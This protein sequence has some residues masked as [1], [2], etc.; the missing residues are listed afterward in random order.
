MLAKWQ[1]WL[2]LY[3]N[4]ALFENTTVH[5]SLWHAPLM[6][7]RQAEILQSHMATLLSLLYH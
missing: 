4:S 5:H 1:E 3:A 7:Q 6:H 2:E